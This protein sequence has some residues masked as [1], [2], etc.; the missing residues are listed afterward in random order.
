MS[1]R[2]LKFD[3]TAEETIRIPA[4]IH[5][6]KESRELLESLRSSYQSLAGNER[7]EVRGLMSDLWE[8]QRRFGSIAKR[9]TLS[10]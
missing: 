10:G 7:R 9:D 5:T 4:K 2:N 3:P 1:G 6:K 8:S